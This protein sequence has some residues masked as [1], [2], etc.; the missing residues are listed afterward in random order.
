MRRFSVPAVGNL[1]V[2]W[3]ILNAPTKSLLL[4][5]MRF[6]CLNSVEESHFVVLKAQPFRRAH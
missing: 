3:F 4:S 2:V 5:V 1:E 6:E